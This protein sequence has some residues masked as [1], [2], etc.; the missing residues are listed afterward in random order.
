MIINNKYSLEILKKRLKIVAVIVILFFTLIIAKLFYLVIRGFFIEENYLIK[1]SL[2]YRQDILDRNGNVLALNIP[3]TSVYINPRSI[4]NENKQKTIDALLKVLKINKKIAYELVNSDKAFVWVKRNISKKQ[5]LE[6]KYYGIIGLNFQIEQKRFYPYGKLFSHIVGIT[7]ID[8]NG[9]SGIEN[10]FNNTL[11]KKNIVLS[12]DT[13]LQQI[14]YDELLEAKNNNKAKA[15]YG[16]IVNPKNFEVLASVSL[17]DF[18]PNYRYSI[19][20]QDMFNYTSQGV[21]EPGSVAKIF[22]AAMFLDSKITNIY[23]S[24]DVSKPIVKNRFVIVDYSY[25][26]R[27][28]ILPEILMYS[29]NVGTSL[30]AQ[31]LGYDLQQEY[32]NKFRFFQKSSIEI[33][34]NEK[35]LLPSKWDELS[36]MVMSYGYG[37]AL[38]QANFLNSF[39][40]MINGGY[41]QPLTLLK[42]SQKDDK[43]EIIDKETSR[44]LRAILRL[45]VSGGSARRADIS[46]YSVA[47][48]T[49]SAEKL[50]NGRYDYNKVIAS[51]VGFFPVYDPQ[52]VIMISIDEPQRVAYNSYN[53]TGGALSAPVAQKVIDKIGDLYGIVKKDDG[54]YLLDKKNQNVLQEYVENM[55]DIVNN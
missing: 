42:D 47:G 45:T 41:Y 17:P 16:M 39:V 40:A 13:S 6:L 3:I 36:S 32:F 9:I 54:I 26:D 21:F 22:S 44:Q 15:V 49:G 38:S 14:L 10:Y 5:E 11:L 33:K 51:F 20:M 25:M 19:N 35:P 53:I 23:E 1:N 43:I 8:G 30:L 2:N 46:G 52:Y 27:S 4:A 24:I 34:E 29:S 48:K 28:L 55:P 50:V 18:N 12:L 31:R 37:Y 7:D